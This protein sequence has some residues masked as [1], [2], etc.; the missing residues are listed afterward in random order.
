MHPIPRTVHLLATII[1]SSGIAV[2][3]DSVQVGH[4]P[5]TVE[6]NGRIDSQNPDISAPHAV[7]RMDSSGVIVVESKI[8][9]PPNGEVFDDYKGGTHVDVLGDGEGFPVVRKIDEA[10]RIQVVRAFTP[11]SAPGAALQVEGN[12]KYIGGPGAGGVN[13]PPGHWAALVEDRKTLI[14]D[15]NQGQVLRTNPMGGFL[16][17]VR[18]VEDANYVED[19]PITINVRT[20]APRSRDEQFDHGETMELTPGTKW[21]YGFNTLDTSTFAPRRFPLAPAEA[22]KYVF[23]ATAQDYQT[24]ILEIPIA[25]ARWWERAEHELEGFDPIGSVDEPGVP[26]VIVRKGSVS[27]A[28]T[29]EMGEAVEAVQIKMKN[30]SNADNVAGIAPNTTEVT[31]TPTDVEASQT[32]AGKTGAKA[33]K[34]DATFAELNIAVFNTRS[35]SVKFIYAKDTAAPDPNDPN[36]GEEIKA[37]HD[38][39][40]G[41]ETEA[42]HFQ[43]MKNAWEKQGAVS[44]TK[45]EREIWTIPE[46]MAD[47]P[48]LTDV[49]A[50]IAARPNCGIPPDGTVY[51]YVFWDFANGVG[52]A[53]RAVGR[54][55]IMSKAVAN[56]KCYAHE[57]GHALGLGSGYGVADY[58]A[59]G[60]RAEDLMASPGIGGIRLHEK[61]VGIVHGE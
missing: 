36:E 43:T 51:F 55:V 8:F 61:Q 13:Q 46:E 10:D 53:G 50:K 25:T 16:L 2:A 37:A 18:A 40:E 26:W 7:R 34:A 35:V 22:T 54:C 11:S 38:A 4:Q 28:C 58:P 14:L 39:T 30:G 15:A 19:V 3:Q 27:S 29:L 20:D 42:A 32:Q 1:L 5:G 49:Y 33:F 47:V 57:L 12:L 59:T 21:D 23:T 45:L 52:A 6:K 24:A 48:T 31:N 9:T 44:L 17:T 60:E 56:D 41:E